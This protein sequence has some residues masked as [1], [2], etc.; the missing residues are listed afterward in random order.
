MRMSFEKYI[1]IVTVVFM[2]VAAI[3]TIVFT[4]L[5]VELL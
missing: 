4:A 5:F 3:G 2:A 1:G